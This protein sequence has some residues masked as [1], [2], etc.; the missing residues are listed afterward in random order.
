MAFA[1]ELGREQDVE[2]GVLLRDT[3][4]VADG[5]GRLDDN[6]CRRAGGLDLVEDG[7]DGTG[8]ERVPVRVVVRGRCDDDEAPVL[9]GVV[10]IERCLQRGGA[11]RQDLLDLCVGDGG[12]AG[13]DLLDLLG[14]DVEGPNVP[15]ACE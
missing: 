8:V 5:N 6:R 9:E 13:V 1:E 2:L 14:Y 12:D 4:R 15:D 3:F 10:G 7:L 11:R